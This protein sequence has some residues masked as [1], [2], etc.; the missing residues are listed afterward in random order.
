MFKRD[1]THPGSIGDEPR[2]TGTG[3]LTSSGLQPVMTAPTFTSPPSP[4]EESSIAPTDT[5]EGKI[6]TSRG[7]RIMGTVKGEIQSD[8]YVHIEEDAR[9]D[10]D[11][12]A[13]EVVIAGDYS[14][15]LTV[16][17]R[18]EIRA[19]GRVSG[20]IDTAKLSLHEGGY[21][22]GSLHMKKPEEIGRPGVRTDG[23]RP[24][25]EAPEKPEAAPA[26]IGGF[27]EVGATPGPPP[28]GSST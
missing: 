24:R 5:F 25:Q 10:A 9:V 21:I 13:D 12:Q 22:H 20:E 27:R 6:R 28:A 1:T 17:Q 4:H 3:P 11:I 26:M 16:N 15:K 2:R 14:G 7:V 23:D 19:T 18:L 8:Q